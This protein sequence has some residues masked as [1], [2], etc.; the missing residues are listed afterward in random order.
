MSCTL[1]GTVRYDGSGFAGWQ[2]QP[3][4]RTVQGVL[5]A[6]LSRIAD[7]AVAVQGAGRTDAGVHALGQVFSCAWP[8][9]F[10]PR[11]RHALCKML[12]PEI[13]VLAL[14]EAPPGFNARFD[15]VAKR[16]LYALDF[17]REPDPFSAR[18]AWHVAHRVDL[19]L[20]A[21]LLPALQ[22]EHDFSGFQ[23]TG[24]QMQHTVR[25]LFEVRLCAGGWSGPLDATHLHRLEFHGDGFLYR[26]VRNL[27]G[28][29]IEIARGRCPPDFLLQQLASGGPFR[30]H[31]APAHGLAL[32]EV[33]YP[34]EHAAPGTGQ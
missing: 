5:E 22:G 33:F 16:Y 4:R 10:T 30:G 7:Q 9:P 20:L 1:K 3:G 34:P 12:G 29:L 2:R 17:S 6:A 24:A 15:A 8:R 26:M 14:E 19:E 11:L 21:S 25:T 28:T 32:A 13:R 23:S 31:C 18:H 27:T